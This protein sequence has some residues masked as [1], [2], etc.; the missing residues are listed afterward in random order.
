MGKAGLNKNDLLWFVCKYCSRAYKQPTDLILHKQN[1][2]REHFTQQY[3]GPRGKGRS[4]KTASEKLKTRRKLVSDSESKASSSG[5]GVSVDVIRTESADRVESSGF[6]EHLNHDSPSTSSTGSTLQLSECLPFNIETLFLNRSIEWF[7]QNSLNNTSSNSYARLLKGVNIVSHTVKGKSKGQSTAQGTKVPINLCREDEILLE[8]LRGASLKEESHVWNFHPFWKLV[9]ENRTI[10]GN[11]LENQT[12][13]IPSLSLEAIQL[14]NI[15]YV[16]N[17][18]L[19]KHNNHPFPLTFVSSFGNFGDYFLWRYGAATQGFGLLPCSFNVPVGD[20]SSQLIFNETY[21]V[22]RGKDTHNFLDIPTINNF[23]IFIR[24]KAPTTHVD[25]F[26]AN[27]VN[28]SCSTQRS[29]DLI[30]A[31]L[32]LALELLREGGIFVIKVKETLSQMAK[33]DIFLMSR[34]F[35]Q[36]SIFNPESCFPGE[37][38]IVCRWKRS[39]REVSAIKNSLYTCLESV[40]EP[41]NT[42]VKKVLPIFDPATD[43]KNLDEDFF[44]YIEQINYQIAVREIALY[45]SLVA[46]SQLQNSIIKR[47]A[48]V[49]KLRDKLLLQWNMSRCRSE[50]E[51][52]E[53]YFDESDPMKFWERVCENEME[54]NALLQQMKE[55]SVSEALSER[56]HFGTTDQWMFAVSSG[57]KNRFVI[58]SCGLHDITFK[59]KQNKWEVIPQMHLPK[60]TVV[61][62]EF[63]YSRKKR[64]VLSIIDALMLDQK[65]VGNLSFENRIKLCAAFARRLDKPGQ[66][67]YRIMF[68]KVFPLQLL[69]PLISKITASKF[70]IVVSNDDEMLPYPP[71]LSAHPHLREFT[72]REILL[73]K[74]KS[75]QSCKKTSQSYTVIDKDFKFAIANRLFWEWDPDA[76]L[77][78]VIEKLNFVVKM[79]LCSDGSQLLK[80]CLTLLVTASR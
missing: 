27:G 24:S 78:G 51:S 2:H 71:P 32:L 12:E 72:A 68:A 15:D 64:P 35:G 66:G 13:I 4:K 26:M 58:I 67:F 39:I 25:L 44:N 8:K 59:W 61:V 1:L 14:A 53:I 70:K 18:E 48:C 29:Q 54:A 21:S 41:R 33:T 42:A 52:P 19:S 45:K 17:D 65:Y 16:L 46:I 10:T 40:Q 73:F 3:F 55:K 6:N 49:L 11:I 57:C 74:T 60:G 31:Q 75:I 7:P 69:A 28:L 43:L 76:D 20:K 50:L 34:C 56:Q 30:L 37:Y 62:A 77:N 23:K 5:D 22:Y 36:C 9:T 63:C 80:Q 79:N 47:E 38:Y